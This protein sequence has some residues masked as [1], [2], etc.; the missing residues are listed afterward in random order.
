M[1]DARF[2]ASAQR[3]RAVVESSPIGLLMVDAR[4]T[5]VLINA[6][7]ERLFGYSRELMF[8]R[9]VEFL[10]PERFRNG[11][12]GARDAFRAN[13]STRQMGAGRELRALRADGTEFP[14]EIGLTPV[15]TDEGLFVVGSI[16]DITARLVGNALSQK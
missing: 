2:P 11:H 3:L 13:P 5:I 7:V 8:G 12:P 14:V 1:P 16:V 15:A 4:G 6:E 10:L 9:Q